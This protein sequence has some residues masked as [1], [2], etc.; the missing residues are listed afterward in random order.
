MTSPL[1]N[2]ARMMIVNDIN[3][4][5]TISESSRR[6]STTRVT[7]RETLKRFYEQGNNQDRPRSGRPRV[8]TQR[9]DEYIVRKVSVNPKISAAVLAKDISE[10]NDT[11]ISPS[12]VRN[13]LRFAGLHG[14]R[15][16]K[17]NLIRPRNQRKR[18]CFARNHASK[19]STFWSSVIFSDESRF[20]NSTPDRGM[21]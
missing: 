2:E 10:I 6:F 5:M 16:R 15:P 3:S 8:I 11:P 12:T 4:G 17:V 9:N 20:E 21:I 18:L 13:R 7:I 1:S 19:D 14:R